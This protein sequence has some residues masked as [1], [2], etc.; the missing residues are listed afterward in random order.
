MQ[1]RGQGARIYVIKK[2]VKHYGELKVLCGGGWDSD[3]DGMVRSC[4]CWYH[5]GKWHWYNFQS[6]SFGK[7]TFIL[8]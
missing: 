2:Y 1:S 6:V 5:S 7:I 8:F 4:W 3:W